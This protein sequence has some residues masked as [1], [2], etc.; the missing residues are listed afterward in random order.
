MSAVTI[1]N[2][3]VH[4]EVLGR[5]RPV[6]LL[7]GWLTSWRYWIPSMQ[8]LSMK[9][10]TYALDL[11][12]YGDSGKDPNKLTLD[13][14]VELLGTFMDKLGIT[15]AAF[16]GHS[17]GAAVIVRFALKYPDR[18]AR[19]MVISAPVFESSLAT[20]PP[21]EPAP[22]PTGPQAVPTVLARPTGLSERIA[23]V[24]GEEAAPPDSPSHARPTV[25]RRPSELDA[26]PGENTP[27]P[28][29][30]FDI[31]PGEPLPRL[32]DLGPPKLPS[33]DEVRTTAEVDSQ[34]NPLRDLL[35]GKTSQDL[36]A[37]HLVRETPE[38]DRLL[39]EAAKTASTALSASATSFDRVDLAHD[40]RRMSTPA[41]LIHG[42]NDHFLPPPGD[43]LSAY[44]VGGKDSFRCEVVP[45]ANH[46]PMLSD[47]TNF[48]RLM[49]DFLEARDLASLVLHKERWVR[50]VR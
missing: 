28:L 36:L 23:E 15:K 19:M 24:S 35:M 31:K 17:L 41:L 18:V 32:S 13:A 44:L 8:Q 42:E 30:E 22:K 50:K 47:P 16:V 1:D 7:H 34:A 2:D 10:R 6:I 25:L 21:E 14:H 4:Y 29:P 46:F 45:E 9:Y 11:W 49:M 3:L 48:H 38:Y 40:M 26:Q 37:A 43:D 33:S 39:G 12:G 20:K 27:P 5:G